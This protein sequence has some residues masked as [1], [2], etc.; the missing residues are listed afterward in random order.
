MQ[1]MQ[2]IVIPNRKLWLLIVYTIYNILILH[3]QINCRENYCNIMKRLHMNWVQKLNVYTSWAWDCFRYLTIIRFYWV[4]WSWYIIYR[5]TRRSNF[6]IFDISSNIVWYNSG[7]IIFVSFCESSFLPK[8]FK[9]VLFRSQIKWYQFIN[10][11]SKGW[12]HGLPSFR[13]NKFLII[14]LACTLLKFRVNVNFYT[15]HSK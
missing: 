2:W 9:G 12:S 5:C 4:V 14:L 10:R 7:T 3:N 15:R 11:P 6:D 1:T 8:F 13:Y